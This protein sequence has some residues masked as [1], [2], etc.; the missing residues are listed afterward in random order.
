MARRIGK[1]TQRS[2]LEFCK[3]KPIPPRTGCIATTG[4]TN[5]PRSA[6]ILQN[7]ANP[8]DG[9]VC[10]ATSGRTNPTLSAKSGRPPISRVVVSPRAKRSYRVTLA[11]CKTKPIRPTCSF[12]R[13]HLAERTQRVRETRAARRHHRWSYRPAPNEATA[14]RS[15][16]AKQSQIRRHSTGQTN[17]AW[18]LT[19]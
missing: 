12:A 11:F 8:G 18:T 6:R 5:R 1:R 2:T 16:S 4:Q 13:Q 3:T 9:P 19:Q 7:K 15:H 10:I 17:P 14:S